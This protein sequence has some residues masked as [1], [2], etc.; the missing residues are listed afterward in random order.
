M[1]TPNSGAHHEA[2]RK[3]DPKLKEITTCGWWAAGCTGLYHSSAVEADKHGRT[4]LS[5]AAP[6]SAAGMPRD[7]QKFQLEC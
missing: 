2:T 4:P 1:Q 3:K 6:V 7:T 5:V